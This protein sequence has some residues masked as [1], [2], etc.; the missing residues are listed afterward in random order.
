MKKN[1][2]HT[3][4]KTKSENS[5][6]FHIETLERPENLVAEKVFSEIAQ[7][8][9]SKIEYLPNLDEK[10]IDG[11]CHS[12]LYGL[13]LAYSEHRP[14]TLSPD[15]LWLL[16]LQG[17]SNHVNY[18]HENGNNLFPQLTEK[19][20]I[21]IHNDKII[22]GDPKS[23]WHETTEEFSNQ[24]EKIVGSEIVSELRADF[25]TTTL[26]SKVVS[27]ITIMDTFKAYFNYIV[28]GAIC[29]IPELKLEGSV[30]D[31]NRVLQ[32]LEVLKK[33]D[34]K[35]WY[36]DLKPI[37]TKI[38]NTAEEIID[39]EFWMHIF[40]VHTVE[41]YGE[42]KSID[43]W[44]T[45]FFPFTDTG[46]KFDIT[47][48]QN[49]QIEDIFKILPKQVVNV[50]FVHI[51]K[52][53]NQKL[54]KTDMEYWG[55]F[56]GITQD[57]DTQ[58]LKPKINWCISHKSKSFEKETDLER[59]ASE[60]YTP[61]KVFNNL[62]VIPD[63]IFSTKIWDTLALHFIGKAIIPEQIKEL[64]FKYLHINGKVDKEIKERLISYFDWK[65][66]RIYINGERLGL[67]IIPTE[68]YQ[69]HIAEI[70][71]KY[72]PKTGKSS[73]VQGE[74]LRIIEILEIKILQNQD[75]NFTKT[76]LEQLIKFLEDYLY[77]YEDNVF[78]E[79]E[80]NEMYFLF[81]SFSRYHE[82]ID[83][84][85]IDH[86]EI[87]RHFQYIKER[88]VDWHLHYGPT[89]LEKDPELCC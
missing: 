18:S 24:I 7:T 45:K 23:P 89:K 63:E 39:N 44:I 14:F 88:M 59:E 28:H 50:N 55:G 82:A 65:K 30:S 27:E 83:S 9:S 6:T 33:Y 21:V 1:H 77:D 17:I 3:M 54:E 26:A 35:W 73:Y 80:V 41:E 2:S 42:P 49:Y 16:V 58:F 10:L 15:M 22:L 19:K 72:I 61:A 47:S 25:S 31:W 11:G 48:Y 38:K 68:V 87:I 81:G 79:N 32:K 29:G 56:M 67:K 86:S 76:C 52:D 40:K 70:K 57:P 5:I 75:K 36:N 37:I 46:K 12:F 51:S 53:K 8:F 62:K 78:F 69:Q 71:E 13:Y 66:T 74:I 84:E 60:Y 43:G 20:N 4:I 64:E 85:Q 34:L